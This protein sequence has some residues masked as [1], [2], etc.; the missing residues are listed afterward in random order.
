MH[1]ISSQAANNL[2]LEAIKRTTD[3]ARNNEADF[4]NMLREASAV[5]QVDTAKMHKRQIVRNEK[6]IAE[7]DVLFRKT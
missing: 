5:K 3:F 1:Y 7:L 2:I 6:R 4:V